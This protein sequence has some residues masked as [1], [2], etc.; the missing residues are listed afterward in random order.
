MDLK[1]LI[2]TG[3]C[4]LDIPKPASE[5]VWW[6]VLGGD[7]HSHI[8]ALGYTVLGLSD[9]PFVFGVDIAERLIIATLRGRPRF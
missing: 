2:G 9:G 5:S 1:V 4:V 6:W 3:H 7:I 8:F